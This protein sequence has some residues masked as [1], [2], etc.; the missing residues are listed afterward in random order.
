MFDAAVARAAPGGA[1]VEIGAGG[2]FYRERRADVLT[3]DLRPGADITVAGNALAMPLR[4]QSV[5]AVLLLNVLHH[6]PDPARFFRECTHVLRPGGR[7]CLI[8][9]HVSFLSRLTIRPFH[10][11]PWDEAAPWELAGSGP[12]SDANMATP[13]AI[14]FRD[15]GRYDAEFPDLPVD[16]IEL[17]TVLLYLVSGGVS[18]RS[19]VPGFAFP[20]LLVAERLLKP[21]IGSLASMMTVELVRR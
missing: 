11:E 7:V 8:E 18:T 21:A 10:H 19:L 13:S 9:P 5:S 12:M 20:P 15:R 3:L 17:H 4:P 16:R 6:L 2:G 1:V 14:F